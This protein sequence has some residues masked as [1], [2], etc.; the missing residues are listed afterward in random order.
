MV[1]PAHQG[2]VGQL[3]FQGSGPRTLADNQVQAEVLHGRVEDFLHHRGQAVDFVDEQNVQG[4]Q[5]GEHEQLGLGPGHEHPSRHLDGL[6]PE[7][8]DARQVGRGFPA[9]AP[10]G[11]LLEILQKGRRRGLGTPHQVF[12]ARPAALDVPRDQLGIEGG[13]D[14]LDAGPFEPG[15]RVANDVADA[16]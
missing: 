16:W 1:A 13:L 4:G 11:Q 10:G 2:E 8:P 3:Q 12:A 15:A 7:F 14:R 5:I 6:A 9:L